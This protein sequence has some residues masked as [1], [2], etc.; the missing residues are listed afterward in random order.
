MQGADENGKQLTIIIMY[1]MIITK[2]IIIIELSIAVKVIE[3]LSMRSQKFGR[4]RSTKNHSHSHH[5]SKRL[6][7]SRS[8][9]KQTLPPACS[10][11]GVQG[12]KLRP[13]SAD[14]CFDCSISDTGSIYNAIKR[15]V[16]DLN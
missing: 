1:R 13:H 12:M 4:S 14:K 9:T 2:T 3:Q 10:G 7:R 6:H 16:I 5:C 15:L 8:W 11:F